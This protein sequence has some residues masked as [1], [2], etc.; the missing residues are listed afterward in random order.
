[1]TEPYPPEEQVVPCC[2]HLRTKDQFCRQ[3]DAKAGVGFVRVSPTTTYWCARTAESFGPDDTPGTPESCQP[4]R[5]CH[6]RTV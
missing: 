2:S 4:G 1:M 3:E 6:E 5:S